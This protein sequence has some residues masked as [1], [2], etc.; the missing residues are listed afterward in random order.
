MANEE[1]SSEEEPIRDSGEAQAEGGQDQGDAL[2]Q[3]EQILDAAAEAEGANASSAEAELTADLQRLQAEFTN[4]RR[5]VERDKEAAREV[6]INGSVN[7][8]IPVLDDIDAAR[9]AGD[10]VEGPF[11]S[12]A[13]KL[14]AALEGLGLERI[15]EVGV[16]FD[17]SIHEALLRQPVPGIADDHVGAVL[18]I[19][20]RRGDRV[21]RAAQVLVSTGE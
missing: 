11:A 10:L 16:E 20:F 4:Y 21:L 9:A 1:F 3:A 2:S 13:G 7:A 19:G 17:P 5:R 8:L 12:I 14:D 18:R 6:G 15:N